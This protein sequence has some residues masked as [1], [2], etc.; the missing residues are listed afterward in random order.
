MNECFSNYIPFH[1]ISNIQNEKVTD[2]LIDEIINIKNF[3]KSDTEKRPNESIEELEYPQDYDDGDESI[4]DDL[5]ENEMN[6]PRVQAIF[7]RYRHNNLSILI[8]SHDYY[9]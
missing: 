1:V 8:L 6:N 2:I 5:D 7:K 4:S 9:E 3:L